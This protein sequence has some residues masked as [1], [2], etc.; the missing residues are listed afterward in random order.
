[1]FVP[2]AIVEAMEA[3]FEWSRSWG[4]MEAGSSFF[5][6]PLMVWSWL[7]HLEVIAEVENDS[8]LEADVFDH[9]DLSDI[10]DCYEDVVEI[11][12]LLMIFSPAIHKENIVA[13]IGFTSMLHAARLGDLDIVE[14]TWFFIL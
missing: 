3:I 14:F 10:G 7:A 12:E 1:M 13:I 9:D 4:R 6:L 11:V 5:E 8:I 2:L